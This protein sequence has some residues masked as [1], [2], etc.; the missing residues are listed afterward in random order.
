[1]KLH[2]KTPKYDNEA[3][4]LKRPLNFLTGIVW[5]SVMEIRQSYGNE[6]MKV[7]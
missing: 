7:D 1:M 3:S 2:S 4:E 5:K 6:K